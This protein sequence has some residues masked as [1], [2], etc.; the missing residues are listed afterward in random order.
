MNNLYNGIGWVVWEKATFAIFL[1]STVF[2]VLFSVDAVN[3]WIFP[4]NQIS[5]AIACVAPF[6][7]VIFQH[8]PRWIREKNITREFLFLFLLVALGVVSIFFG[9]NWGHNFSNFKGMGLFLLPAVGAFAGAFF[10]VKTPKT[11]NLFFKFYSTLLSILCVY[12]IW[13]YTLTGWETCHI[14]PFKNAHDILF[15]SNPI[16]A[17][18]VIICLFAG[19]IFLLA[20]RC[21]PKAK[22]FFNIILAIGVAVIVLMGSRAAILSIVLMVVFFGILLRG[23]YF[24]L[25]VALVVFFIL[26]YLFLEYLPPFVQSKFN[27]ILKIPVFRLEMYPF[28][29][30]IFSQFPL[31][32]IGVWASLESFLIDY[33][34]IF[35]FA[36]SIAWNEF[37]WLIS[38]GTSVHNMILYLFVHMGSLFAS[39]YIL[40]IISIV[41]SIGAEKI[42]DTEVALF[43]DSG[44]VFAVKKSIKES[45]VNGCPN[46]GL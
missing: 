22:L 2:M 17:G 38:T 39:T 16:P 44:S 29:F 32:G 9:R 30:S 10:V 25:F 1:C 35:I 8:G 6:F 45:S 27:K 3:H 40:F 4:W 26:G 24:S 11:G 34:P 23:R 18:A 12:A 37:K 21:S 41:S 13:E 20:Q 36:P 15:S 14:C 46:F 7:M 43:N 5:I 33:S 19:P 42:G 28:A 31:L